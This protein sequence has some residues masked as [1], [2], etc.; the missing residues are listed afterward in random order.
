MS[1]Q[2]ISA[3]RVAQELTSSK[4]PPFTDG[5]TLS[6]SSTTQSGGGQP[7]PSQRPSA[8]SRSDGMSGPGRGRRA[9][10]DARRG[11]PLRGNPPGGP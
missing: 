6:A 2:N 8:A 1:P 4:Y 9:G 5:A 10:G 7:V 11:M 3:R